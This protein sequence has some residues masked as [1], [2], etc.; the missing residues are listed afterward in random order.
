MSTITEARKKYYRRPYEERGISSNES[1]TECFCPKC[2]TKHKV[3]MN[4]IGRGTPK[5]FCKCCRGQI[6]SIR[7]LPSDVTGYKFNI[8]NNMEEPL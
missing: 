3:K 6:G 7:G 1:W 8:N 2:E 5:I 4:W